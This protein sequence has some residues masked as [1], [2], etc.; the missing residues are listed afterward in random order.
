MGGRLWE[1]FGGPIFTEWR[2]DVGLQQ[3]FDG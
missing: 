3:S 2:L 1:G